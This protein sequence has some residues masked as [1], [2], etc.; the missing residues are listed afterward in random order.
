M[1]YLNRW[2]GSQGSWSF[3]SACG[4]AALL[5]S[6]LV[7]APA[8]A[9][10]QGGC[11][12][13]CLP[14]EI[15]NP[16]RT[17]LLHGQLRVL[18]STQYA[19]FDQF[20]EQGRSLPNPGGNRAIIHE[21]TL[22]LDYG[23]SP[24][25]TVSALVPFVRKLQWT[26]RFG[27]RVADGV[28]DLALFGRY[29]VVAPEEGAGPSIA[30]GLGVKFPT[31]DIEQPDSSPA[32]LPPAFQ[33]GSGALDA[34]PTLAY[35]QSFLG[36]ALYGS[37]LYRIPLEDNK[38]GYQFGRELEI[39]VGAQVPLPVWR[40]RL[41]FLVSLDYLHAG[42]DR[43]SRGV[44][45]AQLREGSTVLN[46]GGE[47]LDLTPG[48]RLHVTPRLALQTRIFLP[49]IEHWNGRRDRNVGQVAPDATGQLTLAYSVR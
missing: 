17:Q 27:K 30:L 24:R 15:L 37:S 18:L 26:N 3:R 16:E 33:N 12:S 14:L 46:T 21:T 36:F 43:D 20:R 11:G 39:H 28:G 42:H 35:Y 34:V 7:L 4:A 40:K 1:C 45:P 32:R 22:I 44:L 29:E 41:E 23:V 49:V 6:W 19:E 8:G 5:A 2:A 48:F 38:F 25:I 9:R 31:G 13:V 10:A 47:F